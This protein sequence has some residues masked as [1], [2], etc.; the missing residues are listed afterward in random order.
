MG[1]ISQALR[2]R[3]AETF[4]FRCAYCLTSRRIVGPMLEIDHIIPEAHGGTSDEGNLALACP[5]CNGH[6]GDK[7]N[8]ID[9]TDGANIPLFNPRGDTR[10]EHFEW[11]NDGTLIRGITATGRATASALAMNHPDLV[12]ARRL[13]VLVGWH[14]PLH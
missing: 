13:S 9:P 5:M 8:G 1:Y 10:H 6:K 4:R 2:W 11:A 14:P 12:E 7:R 3:V